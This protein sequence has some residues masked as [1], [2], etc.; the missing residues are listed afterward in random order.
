M[1]LYVWCDSYIVLIYTEHNSGPHRIVDK[2]FSNTRYFVIKSNNFENVEIA[3]SKVS[4]LVWNYVHVSDNLYNINFTIS[5]C[6]VNSTL[7]WK[8]VE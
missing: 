5:E 3:K 6:L 2:L 8:E 7:Q 4:V 1:M